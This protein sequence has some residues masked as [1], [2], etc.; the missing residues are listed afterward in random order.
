[1]LFKSPLSKQ[2]VIARHAGDVWRRGRAVRYVAIPV[3]A[4]SPPP[5]DE[6]ILLAPCHSEGAAR[7][8]NLGEGSPPLSLRAERSNLSAF[9]IVTLS[10]AKN[11]LSLSLCTPRAADCLP[12]RS[13][14]SLP[15]GR[16]RR[17]LTSPSPSP[18][19]FDR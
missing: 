18:F 5:A 8:K 17:I 14:V 1:M 11:P 13:I 9:L 4:G 6:A 16:W 10:A 3:I 19:T 7:P 15:K 2:P 12:Q